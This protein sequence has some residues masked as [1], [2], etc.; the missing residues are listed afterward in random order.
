MANASYFQSSFL[1]G[2]WS[3]YS[4]GRMDREEYL[5]GMN[6]CKNSMPVEEGAWIR[7]PGM[8]FIAPTRH[9]EEAQLHEFHFEQAS[10]YVM[11]FS[12]G[13]LRFHTDGRM[14]EEVEPT[15]GG[16]SKTVL[17]ITAATPPVVTTSTNHGFT[18]GESVQFTIT[19]LS[20]TGAYVL[21]NRLFRVTVTGLT[22]FTLQDE[23][24]GANVD[25]SSINYSTGLSVAK[26][27]ERATPYFAVI[28][29]L[30]VV[31]DARHCYILNNLVTPQLMRVDGVS[32][33]YEVVPSD[34]QD[35][36]Y[37]DP[38]VDGT[39][40]T[41]SA[42]SG[43]VTVTASAPKFA[44]TDIGRDLRLWSE[45]ADWSAVATYTAGQTVKYDDTYWRAARN[46]VA[47]E[48]PGVA[49]DAWALDLTA[50]TWS[51]LEI[52][53]FTSTTVV[54]ATVRENT[55]V[56][57]GP[58]DLWRFG[59]YSETT[60]YPTC[61]VF[62]EGRLWLAGAQPNRLDGSALTPERFD[63]RFSPTAPDGT[64]SDENG[65]SLVLQANDVNSIFWLSA[66][67]Q[68]ITVGTQA[69]EWLIRAAETNDPITPTSAQ[70]FRATTFGC[71][72]IE[73]VKAPLSL[74]FVHRFNQKVV[75]YVADQVNGKY[76]GTNIAL[77]SRHLTRTGLRQLAYQQEAVPI[78][79]AMDQFGDLIGCTYKRE[80]PYA[81]QQALF[82][83]WHW[84]RPGVLVEC[85]EEGE[86]A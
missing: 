81:A 58:I 84:H 73:P 19:D 69:G 57:T 41:T 77:N 56:N 51:W 60:G 74:V 2:E 54:T 52:T 49:L 86:V 7:R 78:V 17:S 38:E 68:G 59:L 13:F 36:P 24:T 83:G 20:Q 33:D 42:V 26:I 85:N 21:F 61:G 15:L 67:Q 43:S 76:T 31:Q 40:L 50:A 53:A 44:A 27:L 48:V 80:S 3:P 16:G 72:N 64:V 9:G 82:Y 4:Q 35:G 28:R 1:G 23:V 47:G 22:T 10:S 79:W 8:R 14:V 45:P 5:T 55:M 25:G 30:R 63:Y 34:F 18:T 75:E 29:D 71:S 46:T 6:R 62:H 12:S 65:V 37:M 39:T 70:A 66:S 11:Q 32:F